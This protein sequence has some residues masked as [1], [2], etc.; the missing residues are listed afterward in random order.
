MI[1][2]SIPPNL[3]PQVEEIID[4]VT[5]KLGGHTLRGPILE[6]SAQ[7]SRADGPARAHQK[8]RPHSHELPFAACA[9]E[10]TGAMLHW[11][12]VCRTRTVSSRVT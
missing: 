7:A 9:A 12:S 6:E 11:V 10:S 5:S 8:A 1:K 4:G 3:A 2:Q